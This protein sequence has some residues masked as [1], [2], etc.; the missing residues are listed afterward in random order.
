MEKVSCLNVQSEFNAI[1][2]RRDDG[3]RRNAEWE[4]A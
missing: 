1:E 2:C 4:A 3:I